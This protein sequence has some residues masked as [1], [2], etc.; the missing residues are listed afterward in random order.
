MPKIRIE[1]QISHAIRQVVNERRPS[2]LVTERLDIRGKAKSKGMSRLVNYWM[3]G[4]LQERLDFL[5]LVEGFHHKQ[6]NPAYTSQMCPTCLFVHG[7]NRKGDLFQCLNCGHRD[8]ADRVAAINL[9]A[10]AYEPDI[11]I[12]TPK[13]VVKAIL[14]ARF[15]KNKNAPLEKKPAS[16]QISVGGL[17]VS[18]MT[19]AQSRV[20][21]S[22]TPCLNNNGVGTE[23]S[24]FSTF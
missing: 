17:T 24:C 15:E 7:D 8:Q 20:R 16:A 23:M 18:G 10:R 9:K 14:L 21:Q 12:Y 2:I 11:T 4:I 6:V 5:A 3:R 13:S 1:Q 22:E 19:D